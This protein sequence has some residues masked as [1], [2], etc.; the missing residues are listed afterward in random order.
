MVSLG[1]SL[2]VTR[3][4]H[5]VLWCAGLHIYERELKSRLR[6]NLVIQDLP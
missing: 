4:Q 5:A 3:K 1:A 6:N 2:D